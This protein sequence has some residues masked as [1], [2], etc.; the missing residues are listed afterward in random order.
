M[1]LHVFAGKAN[2]SDGL[3]AHLEKVGIDCEEID[4]VINAHKHN[5]LTDTVFHQLLKKARKGEFCM[6]VFG[7]P[8]STFSVARIKTQGDEEGE[9]PRPVRG[10]QANEREGKRKL[11]REEQ[12]EVKVANMLVNRSVE[13]AMAIAHSGGGVIFE[14]PSDRGNANSHSITCKLTGNANSLF[15][16]SSP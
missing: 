6:G 12:Y 10:R 3:A 13:L 11:T 9:G 1:L 5:L 8:C 14:N 7:V 15:F 4:T 16:F 2:K